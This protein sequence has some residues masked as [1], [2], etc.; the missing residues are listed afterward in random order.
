MLLKFIEWYFTVGSISILLS[1]F[2][3]YFVGRIVGYYEALGRISS[4]GD[5]KITKEDL[6]LFKPAKF[7]EIMAFAILIWP[8]AMPLLVTSA[9][10]HFEDFLKK[11]RS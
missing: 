6:D 4:D 10:K 2:A 8:Y 5:E 1:M 3:N 11:M 9:Y 7:L